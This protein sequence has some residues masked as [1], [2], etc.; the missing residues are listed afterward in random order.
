MLRKIAFIFMLLAV[1]A[2]ADAESLYVGT[3]NIRLKNTGDSIQGDGWKRR[4]P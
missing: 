1:Y 3:Y 4:C 2:A